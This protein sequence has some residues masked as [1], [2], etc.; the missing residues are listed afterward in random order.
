MTAVIKLFRPANC[1]MGVVGV[2]IG[3]LVGVGLDIFNEVY[4]FDILLGCF[5]AFMFMAAGNMLNDYFDSELDRINHPERPIPAGAI[6][7]NQVYISAGALF[8]ILLLLGALINSLM[9]F[10][11]VLAT[12]LM[13]GYELVFKNR[14]LVGNF[15]IGVLTGLLFLFGA[16]VVSEFGVVMILFFFAI[17]A[18]LTR[19]IIKD[20]EDIKGDV[21]RITLPKSI[22]IRNASI[23][24]TAV[25]IL[26]VILSPLPALPQ[27]IPFFEFEKLSLFYLLIIIPA[28][29]LFII[30]IRY[31]R[32]NPKLAQNLLKGGMAVA[33]VAFALGSII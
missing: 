15:T 8:I 25:I 13:I 3:A 20:I 29:I 24:A 23:V 9:F 6:S 18:T 11:L 2:L 26:A 30:S 12:F 4:Y 28:D 19:E 16:A 32:K 7:A 31:F 33:L 14:G 17:L 27:L 21:G 22:G 5:I 1:I 10:I